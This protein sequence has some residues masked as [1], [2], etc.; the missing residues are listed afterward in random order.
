MRIITGTLKGRR[1][2]IPN[3]LDV[4]PTTDRTK[5]GLF[6]TIDSWK[7][8]RDSRVL[9]LF[10]GSGSLGFEAI[11]RG[12][13]HAL[14][15]DESHRNIDH[16]EKLASDFDVSDLI[17]TVAMDVKQFLQGPAVPYDFIFAD[18]PYTYKDLNEIVELVFENG[19]LNDTGWLIL[20]HN[21]H[22]DFRDHKYSL[23]EKEYGKTLI[24][25]LSLQANE[26]DQS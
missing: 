25:I 15:V 14:F 3:N 11:S 21:T 1:I 26:K 19:W 12:A 2:D 22:Y 23:M 9:D 24:S 7:Y 8:I 10:A 16:I 17:R 6:S 18:P 5:E 4:R 13:A 20:E